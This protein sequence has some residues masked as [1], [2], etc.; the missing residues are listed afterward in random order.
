MLKNITRFMTAVAVSVMV[1]FSSYARAVHE[2]GGDMPI[3]EESPD[4]NLELRILMTRE[5]DNR[6]QA[7]ALVELG[8]RP[9]YTD[10]NHQTLL[11]YAARFGNIIHM[12]WLVETH[13]LNVMARDY[14]NDTPAHH[15]A[16]RGNLEAID[17]LARHGANLDAQNF[18]EQ[19]VRD[20]FLCNAQLH[21]GE[22]NLQSRVVVPNDTVVVRESELNATNINSQSPEATPTQRSTSWS[23]ASSR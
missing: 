22:W 17:W 23:S 15:A 6:V 18:E 7:S 14:H 3:K 21:G 1:I 16:R 11:H 9:E 4:I 13:H 12:Q 19:T 2:N 8:A 10:D 5:G 20:L